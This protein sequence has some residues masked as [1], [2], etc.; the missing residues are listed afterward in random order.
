MVFAV[1]IN[2]IDPIEIFS[3]YNKEVMGMV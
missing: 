2:Q 1:G 3:F